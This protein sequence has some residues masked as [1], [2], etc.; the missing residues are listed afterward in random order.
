MGWDIKF[1]PVTRDVI[2][3]GKGSIERTTAADT[4]VMHQISIHFGKWW[5]SKKIGS[6]LHDLRAFG[7]NPEVSVP[8]EAKR[9]LGVLEESGRIAAIEVVSERPNAGRVQLLTRFRDSRLGR[10]VKI[11]TTVGA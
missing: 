9:A 10:V 11:T 4:L 8:A 6:K 7:R 2:S 1:D 5:G 3:D